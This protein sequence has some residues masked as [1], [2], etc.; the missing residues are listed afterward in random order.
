MHIVGKLDLLR[1]E[2]HAL[3]QNLGLR[4]LVAEGLPPVKQLEENHPDRKNVHFGGDARGAVGVDEA[5]WREVPVGP[6]SLAGE[7]D[8][9]DLLVS[10][11]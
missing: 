2:H 1:V 8:F 4:L 10:D 7:R 6:D 9:G 11:L 5:F 3:L